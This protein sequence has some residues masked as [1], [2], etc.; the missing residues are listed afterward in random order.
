LTIRADNFYIGSGSLL[1]DSLT[2]IDD[3]LYVKANEVIAGIIYS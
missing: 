3:K 1:G 2:M